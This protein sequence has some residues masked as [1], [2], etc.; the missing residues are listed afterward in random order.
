MLKPTETKDHAERRRTGPI[1]STSD[2]AFCLMP[3]Y[4]AN[5][6]HVASETVLLACVCC[7]ASDPSLAFAEV[8][9]LHFFLAMNMIVCTYLSMC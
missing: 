6:L 5:N 8:V 4:W 1:S 7:V 2:P 9:L 3:K